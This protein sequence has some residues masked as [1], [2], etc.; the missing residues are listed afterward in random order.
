MRPSR[1]ITRCHVEAED[2]SEAE[3]GV[4]DGN[5]DSRPTNT[6]DE[7][8][9]GEQAVEITEVLRHGVVTEKTVKLQEAEQIYLQSGIGGK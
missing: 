2:V 4:A 8:R 9:R 1:R 3:D 5:I 7:H 6:A